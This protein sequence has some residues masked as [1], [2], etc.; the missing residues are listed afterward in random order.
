ML[1]FSNRSCNASKFSKYITQAEFFHK[2]DEKLTLPKKCPNLEFF[3]VRIFSHLDRIQRFPEKNGPEEIPN[4][5]IF[6]AV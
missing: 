3:P 2:A 4:L 6:H 5:D 1:Q